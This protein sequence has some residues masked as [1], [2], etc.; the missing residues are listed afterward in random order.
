[1]FP[2]I[3][4]GNLCCAIVSAKWSLELGY[5]QLRQMLI[6]AASLLLGPIVL[7]NLYIYIVREAA[8]HGDKGAEW[9]WPKRKLPEQP[10]G[11]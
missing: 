3:F 11:H 2:V 6:F 8:K 1:M 7:A 4:Y 10:T 5:S 9:F